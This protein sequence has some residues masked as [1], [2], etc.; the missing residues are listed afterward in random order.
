MPTSMVSL[1]PVTL[2][3]LAGTW[4]LVVGTLLF[5]YWQLR[6][7]QLLHSAT[8][9][10][11]L[12]ERFYNARMTLARKELST[13]LL[14]SN[15][16]EDPGNWEVVLFFQLL[17]SLTHSRALESRAVWHAFGT[18][19]TAYYVF[20]T[21]PV[22]LLN[23]WRREDSDPLIFAEFEWLAKRMMDF[24]QRAT[25]GPKGKRASLDEVRFI[26]EAE[27]VVAVDSVRVPPAT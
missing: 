25:G 24:D 26:L 15:R 19:I 21:E 12:R 13:W 11:D 22:D 4:I 2:T 14:S 6:Q 8:T 23:Q 7:S 17:G 27:S 18:W 9:L 3:A 20:M 1:D 10:L 16:T 5:A